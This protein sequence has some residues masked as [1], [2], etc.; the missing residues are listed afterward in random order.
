MYFLEQVY[1]FAVSAIHSEI[2]NMLDQILFSRDS[3]IRVFPKLSQW[4]RDV[5]SRMLDECQEDAL[6]E[7]KRLI[8]METSYINTGHP[9]FLARDGISNWFMEQQQQMAVGGS[10]SSLPQSAA[11]KKSHSTGSAP[12][13]MS[14][15][16][17][18]KMSGYLTK[19]G[20]SRR[21]W[22]S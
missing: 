12:L 22:K 8:R 20:G 19:M 6:A 1:P 9:D 16:T 15:S 5:A 3:P 7:V 18:G 10:T 17:R 13:H 2:N 4:I 11:A 14:G 21:S